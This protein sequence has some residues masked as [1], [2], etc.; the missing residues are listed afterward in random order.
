MNVE[1]SIEKLARKIA[2]NIPELQENNDAYKLWEAGFIEGF[3]HATQNS[4]QRMSDTDVVDGL[5]DRMLHK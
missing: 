3:K 5:I 4:H 1:H 2:Q